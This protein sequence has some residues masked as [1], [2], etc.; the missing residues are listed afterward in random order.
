MAEVGHPQAAAPAGWNVRRGVGIFALVL[1]V[2]LLLL[3]AWATY[4][5]LS[6]RSELETAR[7]DAVTARAALSDLDVDAAAA[8]F[9]D[10]AAGFSSGYERLSG[11]VLRGAAVLPV[12]GDD[13]AAARTL[14]WAGAE[15]AEAGQAVA[16]AVVDLGGLDAF[17]PTDGRLPVTAVA[18]L[19]EPA[20]A[21][22]AGLRGAVSA[23]EDLDAEGLVG[24]VAAAR[25]EFLAE[26]VEA[27]ELVDHAARIT[28]VLPAL[29]GADEPRRYLFAAQ[30]PAE[31]RGTGGFMGAYAVLEIDDGRLDFSDFIPV[32]ALT[33]LH[34][35]EVAAPNPDFAAR[36]DRFGGAGFWQAINFTPDFPSAAT[37][38]EQLWEAT[39]G[40]AVDGVIA[41]DPLA[42]EALLAVSGPVAVPGFGEVGAE[43]VVEVVAN[44]AYGAFDDQ[45][46]R[47]EVL[48]GIAA[49]ALE[50]ALSGGDLGPLQGAEAL[51]AAAR[52]GHLKMHASAP[53]EQRLLE[54]FGL[55]GALGDPPG[56]YLSVV[57]NSGSFT[58]L[59]YYTER[60]VTYHVQLHA[61]GS[62][63]GEVRV[64][65]RNEAPTEGLPKRVIGPGYHNRLE[66]GEN[67][68]YVSVLCDVGCRI[69]QD[70][71]LVI[72]EELGHGV[73]SRFV[74]VKSGETAAVPVRW[75]APDAWDPDS[76]EYR[77]TYVAQPT[78]RPTTLSVT[79]DGPPGHR[80]EEAAWSGT[81]EGEER[82]ITKVHQ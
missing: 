6:A 81:V 21:A 36:Y 25:D 38:I 37:A 66:V 58:K 46:V 69:T 54:D 41:V 43:R 14:A 44:E 33:S 31:L 74:T 30:N 82:I 73:A 17:R 65:F 78:I 16:D 24:P 18:A 79:I 7:A 47:K 68:S 60:H 19:A 51:L 2:E 77:L 53:D 12:V 23:V 27:Q 42:F 8:A 35:S 72:E 75:H 22:D 76:E 61:D 34:V 3:G 50:G 5:G 20:A 70:E 56:D 40:T 63:D 13:V 62:A 67:R 48:G 80:V 55:A 57:V 29:L 32:Q 59:D 4:Q 1:V 45:D 11:P 9:A 10:S 28:A 26:S 71:D 49:G 15:V 39:E 52:G 64:Q